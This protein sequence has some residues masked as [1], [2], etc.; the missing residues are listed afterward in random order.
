MESEAIVAYCELG[1]SRR[2]YQNIIRLN[3]MIKAYAKANKIKYVDYHT[4]LVDD[5]GGLPECYASD[6]V[7]PNMDAYRIMESIL[8][9]AL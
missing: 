3:E 8:M 1:D 9:E 7:H 4:A 6:G 2:K 5:R